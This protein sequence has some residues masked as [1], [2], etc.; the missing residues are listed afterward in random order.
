MRRHHSLPGLTI[1]HDL[2]IQSI[3]NNTDQEYIVHTHFDKAPDM[4]DYLG[5]KNCHFYKFK[6]M[7]SH[8]EQVDTIKADH[9][10]EN[11]DD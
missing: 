8:N 10:K 11:Q 9:A 5:A 6:D 4:F 1:N 3:K 2:S 7:D